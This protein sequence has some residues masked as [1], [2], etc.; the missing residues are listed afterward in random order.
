MILP[1]ITPFTWPAILQCAIC[2]AVIGLERQLRG[3]PVGIRT[4]T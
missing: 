4:S 3:K 2:G 1:E